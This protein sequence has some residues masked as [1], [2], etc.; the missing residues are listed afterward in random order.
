MSD[1]V[2]RRSLLAASGGIAAVAGLLGTAATPAAMAQAVS[3]GG[4]SLDAVVK[5][6][7]LK[8]GVAPAEPWY[9]KDPA[10]GQV[11]GFSVSYCKA[12]ADALKI[13]VEFEEFTL[14]TAVAALQAGR[15]DL[16]PVLDGTPERALAVDFAMSPLVWHV[17]SLLVED[18]VAAKT[19]ADINK[20][21][22]S[23][24]VPQGSTM[25]KN[26]RR[27]APKAQLLSFANNPEATAA[28]QSKRANAVSL[29]G[30]ALAVQQS[31]VKRGKILVLTPRQE[32]LSL[33]AVRRDADRTFR[34]W[35]DVSTAYFYN[36]NQ[37]QVW[38]E[39]YMRSR[40]IDPETLPAIRRELWE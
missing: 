9:F 28:F 27:L 32:A 35:V 17:Q 29:F 14:A 23:I 24:A 12:L 18:G 21:G 4:S 34:D 31:R 40:G 33:T 39:E 11:S 22:F 20:P 10:N 3:G 36:T 15:V 37:T 25:E 30:P 19:W 26:V 1:T 38:F 2:S 13:K 5:R 8:V 16:V 6:G 7:V